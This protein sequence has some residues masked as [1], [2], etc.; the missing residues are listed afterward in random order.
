MKAT[1]AIAYLV[2]ISSILTSC[3]TGQREGDQNN[4]VNRIAEIENEI[5]S[6][7]I[8]TSGKVYSTSFGT[9]KILPETQ[10]CTYPSHFSIDGIDL[11]AALR[12]IDQSDY[13]KG[14]IRTN[15]QADRSAT[16]NT[17]QPIF[18]RGYILPNNKGYP[19][20]LGLAVWQGGAAWI[21][22]VERLNGLA[23]G[24]S[25]LTDEAGK[26]AGQSPLQQSIFFDEKQLSSEFSTFIRL[27]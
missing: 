4:N 3:H 20:R 7:S 14:S 1:S 13:F 16:C 8:P 26:P 9:F 19:Y 25:Q 18:I 2:L 15:G 12:S 17:G 27:R 24:V 10:F 11:R 21:G 22:V 23:P 6:R 5:R